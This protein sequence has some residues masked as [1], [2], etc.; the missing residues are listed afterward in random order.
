MRRREIRR[1]KQQQANA[2]CVPRGTDGAQPQSDPTKTPQSSL[3][4]LTRIFDTSYHLFCGDAM[5]RNLSPIEDCCQEDCCIIVV[6]SYHSV[7]FTD[8][9]GASSECRDG[10]PALNGGKGHSCCRSSIIWSFSL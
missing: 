9:V 10:V 4:G 1:R 8:I 5:A 6:G 7:T 2:S 3:H